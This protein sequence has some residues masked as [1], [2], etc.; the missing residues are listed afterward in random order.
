MF[1][2]LLGL[3]VLTHWDQVMHI[4]VSELG[5]HRFRKW[6]VAWPAP[7]HYLILNQCWG[8]ADCT[9]SNKFQLNLNKSSYIFIQQNAFENSGH[10]VSASMC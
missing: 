10:F 9:L 6:L 4:Y 7:S 5:H 1:S 8:I 3:N 2:I